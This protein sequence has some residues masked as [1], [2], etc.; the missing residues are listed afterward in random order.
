MTKGYLVLET[1]EIFEGD[2][3][4]ALKPVTGEVVFNT[5]MTGYQEMMTDPSYAGQILTFCYPLIGNYGL[6]DYDQESKKIAV[7]AVIV[8]DLCEEPSHYQSSRTFT[9]QLEDEGIP[10]LKNID[11]RELVSVIRQHH[12]VRGKIVDDMEKVKE[13]S[14]ISETER[15][16]IDLV[17]VKESVTFDNNGPHVVMMDFGYK[18]SI[19]DALLNEGCKVTIVPYESSITDIHQLNPD[20]ILLSNGPGDP[21]QMK[22]QFSKIKV[23]TEQYP[24]LGICLGHQLIALAHGAKTKKM[25]FGHRGGNHPVKDIIS[26]KVAITSQNHG[27]VVEEGSINKAT[28]QIQFQNVNDGSLEGI[29]HHYLP[30][31][32]VQFH[33]EGHPGPSDTAYIFKQFIQQVEAAGGE[34]ICGSAIL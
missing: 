30:I 20:G 16:L 32:T 21:M 31:Q 33:P 9:E 29:K 15:N 3:I 1:G 22:A 8:N 10:G 4:G 18:K 12:T 26:G 28:F 14:W 5:S 13:L 17:S 34:E 2:W 25:P 11:T 19:L 24:T 6:N 27:Y 7:S 23:I